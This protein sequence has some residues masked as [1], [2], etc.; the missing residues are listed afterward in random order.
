MSIPTAEH[1]ARFVT[2]LQR[3]LTEGEFVST[4]KFALLLAL[5]RWALG[6][7]DR[8]EHLPLDVGNLAPHFAELYWPH[9]RAFASPGTAA[10]AAE[11]RPEYGSAIGTGWERIL[12]Q[13]R[14]QRSAHQVPRV[15]KEIRAAQAGG[16]AQ[17]HQ[18]STAERERLLRVVRKSIVDMPLWKLHRVRD[19]DAPMHFLYREG[20]SRHEICFERGMLACLAHF[21][22][23]IEE[24]VRAA[25]LRH[26][27]SCNPHLLGA[28]ASVETF[29]FPD[30][31]AGLLPWRRVLEQLQG[32]QCFYCDRTIRGTPAVDHFLPWTR[33]RR[34]LG[35]NF[36]LAHAE[37]NQ[38]KR[39]HLASSEH[40]ERWCRRNDDDGAALATRFDAEHLPHDWPTLRNVGASLY[41]LAAANGALLWR[42]QRELVPIDDRW[43]AVLGVA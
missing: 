10:D 38:H 17:F 13:D 35:H 1:Q 22:P 39:D 3:L 24:T 34:D 12:V 43:R 27:L 16:A 5:T 42:Q 18:L 14:G 25:W 26:V 32:N 11:P 8:D 19:S 37:C 6:S 29:L 7:P 31:R 4:Y 28:V 23:L 15:L 30:S 33:Y 9:V 41:Q 20:P 36:V 21:A 40:L 2:N